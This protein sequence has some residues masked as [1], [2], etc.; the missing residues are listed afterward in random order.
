M[1][2]KIIVTLFII[3]A[4]ISLNIIFE[5]NVQA[6]NDENAFFSDDI[7]FEWEY[8]TEGEMMA[9]GLFSPSNAE[10]YESL[11]MIVWLHGSGESAAYEA[12]LRNFGL[13]K[14]IQKWDLENFSAYVLCPHLCD[15]NG[16]WDDHTDELETLLDYII[17]EYNIDTENIVICGESRGGTGALYM[18]NALSEYFSKCAAF[19]AFYSGPFNTSMD[20]LCFYSWFADEASGYGGYL[21]SAFGEERVFETGVGHGSVGYTFFCSDGGKLAESR[22]RNCTVIDVQI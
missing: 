22:Y 12:V 3:I 8:F 10:E 2:K 5:K 21:K 16:Y 4:I 14:A 19:S 11:P 17:E 9:Y 20:T 7:T 18:A 13:T 1:K 15:W 6:A